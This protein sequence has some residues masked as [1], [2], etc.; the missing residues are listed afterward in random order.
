MPDVRYDPFALHS[1]YI[2]RISGQVERTVELRIPVRR[3]DYFVFEGQLLES[4]Q[5]FV[6]AFEVA[7]HDKAIVHVEPLFAFFPFFD[8]NVKRII[9]HKMDVGMPISN[10]HGVSFR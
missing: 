5:T 1:A 8:G 7:E 9:V 10:P 4:L 3:K 2:S 6:F